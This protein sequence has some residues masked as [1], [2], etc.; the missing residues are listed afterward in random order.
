MWARWTLLDYKFCEVCHIW[1]QDWEWTKL[2]YVTCDIFSIETRKQFIQAE[3]LYFW[4]YQTF[5]RDWD[6]PPNSL[7]DIEIDNL[8]I[9]E[10]QDI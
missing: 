6:S 5:L 10:Q 3:Y 2:E 4:T 8:A 9:K 1:R 7:F